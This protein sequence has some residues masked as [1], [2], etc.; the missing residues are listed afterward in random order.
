MR[1]ITAIIALVMIQ[2]MITM[3]LVSALQ[4]SG[5]KA[6]DITDSFAVI[7]WQTDEPADSRV[8][9]GTDRA[10]PSDVETNIERIFNHSI[11]IG[12]LAPSTT[13]YYK[14]KS[15][16]STDTE[17]DD[18]NGGMYAF[19]TPQRDTTPPHIDVDIPQYINSP[20]IDIVGTTEPLTRL[21]LYING[22]L[23]RTFNPKERREF[24]FLNVELTAF[25]P[26]EI[27]L[28]ATD[29]AGLTTEKTFTTTVDLTI[30]EITLDA[31]PSMTTD[32]S[33]VVSG[34]ISETS[35]LE[36]YRN[37]ELVSG[38][39]I[40]D[41]EIT[42][43]LVE[44]ENTIRLKAIDQAG[45][46]DEESASI[47][48]DTTA[49]ELK[50]LK[51]ADTTFFYEGATQV[52]ISGNTEPF[53]KVEVY[54][55]KAP[56]GNPHL[57][58]QA[59][60]TGRFEF[61][62]VD[63]EGISFG[64]ITI[65]G[66]LNG[67]YIPVS[68]EELEEEVEILEEQE[69]RTIKVTFVVTDQA[70]HT[71]QEEISYTIGT[72][73]A[74]GAN[75]DI[76]NLIE[77]QSP[78]MLNP[79][80]LKQGTGIIS[81]VFNL[82]YQGF[83][84]NASIIDVEFV[85]ACEA[86][87]MK[88]GKY[89]ISCRILQ[90]PP[91]VRISNDRKNMWYL[92]YNLNA[93]SDYEEEFLEWPIKPGDIEDEILF[94]FKIKI[95]YS[96]KIDDE[97]ITEGQTT[98]RT[99]AFAID[100][101]RIDPRDVPLVDW[102]IEE[103]PEILNKTINRI[104]ENLDK[105][106]QAV[107][108]SA[109]ACFA[110][111][112]VRIIARGI[113]TWKSWADYRLDKVMK[114]DDGTKCPPPG[115]GKANPKHKLTP[116]GKLTKGMTQDDL[117][118]TELEERCKSAFK[119]WNYEAS[120]Y[121][122]F[123]W[124]CDRFLCSSA[125]AAWTSGKSPEE[126]AVRIERSILCSKTEGTEGL[127]LMRPSA[128]ECKEKTASKKPLCWIYKGDYYTYKADAKGENVILKIDDD[129]SPV[130]KKEIEVVGKGRTVQLSKEETVTCKKLCKGE[131]YEEKESGCKDS[132]T[133][134]KIIAGEKDPV[135]GLVKQP[136]S[137]VITTA[138][139]CLD[140][141]EI[142]L[143]TKK[144]PE[145]TLANPPQDTLDLVEKT[146]S[147]GDLKDFWDYRY[148]KLG[149][150]Y[151]KYVY[152][153]GRDQSAC[154]GANSFIS[155]GEAYL[156]PSNT[157]PAFQCLCTTQIRNRILLLRNILQGLYNC[158]EQIKAT[159][160]ADAGVCK[161]FFTQYLCEWI[162]EILTSLIK[163]C[164]P[165]TGAKI[166]N[167]TTDRIRAGAATI[168]DAVAG[169]TSD[170]LDQYPSSALEDFIGVGQ[171]AI[172]KKICLGALTGDW[173]W[174]FDAFLDTAYSVPYKTSARA[175][176][177]SRRYITW[178]PDTEIATYQYDVAWMLAPG[179]EID[180][181]SVELVCA[182]NYDLSFPG[183][184]CEIEPQGND[185][186]IEKCDCYGADSRHDQS[187]AGPSKPIYTS[188]GGLS[189][190]VFQ[191]GNRNLN[192]ENVYR[193]DNVKISLNVKNEG[194]YEKCIPDANKVGGKRGVFYSSLRDRTALDIIACRWNLVKGEFVC[195][196]G[197]L[198]WDQRGK[199]Y[200]GNIRCDED[201]RK[202]SCEQKTWYKGDN[203][204]IDNIPIYLRGKEQCLHY[205]LRNGH[206][207]L[208]MSGNKLIQ[209]NATAPKSWARKTEALPLGEI[210]E[211]DFVTGEPEPYVTESGWKPDPM[212]IVPHS[213]VIFGDYTVLFRNVNIQEGKGEYIVKGE[214]D[215]WDTFTQDKIVAI[216]GMRFRMK[217]PFVKETCTI[218][219][220]SYTK[221][222]DYIL[223]IKRPPTSPS[224]DPWKLNLQL[225]Y[226]PETGKTCDQSVPEDLITF[227]ESP[228]KKELRLNVKGDVRAEFPDIKEASINE[229]LMESPLG[230]TAD[231]SKATES[232]IKI[233]VQASDN[234]Q[235]TDI[236]VYIDGK[237]KSVIW[238]K[239]LE[240]ES[241]TWTTDEI[242]LE[243][244]EYTIEVEVIDNEKNADKVVRKIQILSEEAI[245]CSKI[246]DK[247]LTFEFKNTPL[248]KAADFLSK[249]IGVYIDIWKVPYAEVTNI[250][251]KAENQRLKDILDANFE[252]ECSEKDK[253]IIITDVKEKPEKGPFLSNVIVIDL[254]LNLFL[255]Y[256]LESPVYNGNKGWEASSSL[257]DNWQLPSTL[258]DATSPE[259]YVGE[260]DTFL[261]ELEKVGYREGLE[262][263]R[264]FV[265]D[266][267]AKEM[268]KDIWIYKNETD[269]REDKNVIKRFY[270]EFGTDTLVTNADLIQT[271]ILEKLVEKKELPYTKG[272]LDELEVG[273]YID[274]KKI[275]NIYD[276]EAGIA[277]IQ[278]RVFTLEDGTQV[279][280]NREH[281]YPTLIHS[282]TLKEYIV[283]GVTKEKEEQVPFE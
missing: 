119:G 110:G 265:V 71:A 44:G 209:P 56:D 277:H 191:D 248:S 15:V 215:K 239:P 102:L 128:E 246:L 185:M 36:I 161:E 20:R 238:D 42:I 176:P 272:E 279:H 31:L 87:M 59:S 109:I 282:G 125:P 235:I 264:A 121:K 174:D 69:A 188:T 13:Y 78:S 218:D 226:F 142:C 216:G 256:N 85:K 210:D 2:L 99:L 65:K 73:Y 50:N 68:P 126:V 79:A 29:S 40:K 172:A 242:I 33:I 184:R 271:E 160:E 45:N 237:Q 131:G 258:A 233:S 93:L 27:R 14:V 260:T 259:A 35:F 250:N 54:I 17:E 231:I 222:E 278:T 81:A 8:F 249:N 229:V 270:D 204:R 200:F 1:K 165:W 130:S 189:Q 171:G 88:K 274:T 147:A 236:I 156:D 82:S 224:A 283:T 16:S 268:D 280:Y 25:Q 76:A 9:Y 225:R 151:N 24:N 266:E 240:K 83:G 198:L 105:I 49:P 51:P 135:T 199:A 95:T 194:D 107:R 118:N 26:N 114:D 195:D 136:F 134:S 207:K 86:D 201:G 115:S 46:V 227:R 269:A 124:S 145:N 111:F 48:L 43:N 244:K 177:A 212:G 137:R 74:G 223:R 263:I 183:A 162:A 61:D 12:N 273:D 38:G 255:R 140:R 175:Y 159:G 63:L 5:I 96:H 4:I 60:S 164:T 53:A 181:Y 275:T 150:S 127:I 208:I 262:K 251:I 163:G 120:A 94:P 187:K 203:I 123:R 113:R 247:R 34:T 32:P 157:V 168:R 11:F 91:N 100:T 104:N 144:D 190:G 217:T 28:A 220:K 97:Q 243:P 67:E 72:C 108:I 80:S 75:W 98:C 254:L 152:Y 253:K 139:E 169:T 234:E 143:C 267:E 84:S 257:R 66:E 116:D 101:S 261:R 178:N 58:G 6:E 7:T 132:T 10:A 214:M 206:N 180:S 21:E 205:E 122:F 167:V 141:D 197:T 281:P 77:H 117:T 70:G 149:Y 228:Q 193:Y 179:C 22:I 18:N 106:N 186:P 90:D 154:F 245:D 47:T 219:G 103:G 230:P 221:C 155:P 158:L 19:Q 112:A 202:I 211:A 170:L 166:S 37:E 129:I 232:P 173:G 55:N 3:P 146:V 196:A 252:Y 30:P 213:Q 92:V 57:K 182:T 52:D 138:K 241:G 23:R 153:E 276:Y 41:F 64:P 89:E 192:A 39:R 133:A 148:D 62:Y